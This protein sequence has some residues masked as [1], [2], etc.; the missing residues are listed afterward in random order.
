MQTPQKP[1]NGQAFKPAATFEPKPRQTPQK[2]SSKEQLTSSEKQPQQ[3]QYQQDY[4]SQQRQN[5]PRGAMNGGAP[6]GGHQQAK[7]NVPKTDFDF[8]TA[9]AKLDKKEIAKQLLESLHNGP[10]EDISSRMNKL[11]LV[12]DNQ[13]FYDKKSSFFDDISCTA[14]EKS[15]PEA[16]QVMG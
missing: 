15:N 6:R 13:K 5:R 12:E 14:K 10:L 7:F 1:Q 3:Q 11:D 2:Q 16:Q 4:R 9:N 8:D